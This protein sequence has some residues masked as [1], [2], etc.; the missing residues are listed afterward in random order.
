[1]RIGVNL[2]NLSEDKY[3]GVQQYLE[4]LIGHLINTGERLKLFLF[5]TYSP[6]DM[7]QYEHPK[8]K[9]IIVDKFEIP[10]SIYK[11]L[12]QYK[13]HLWFCPLHRSYIQ[14]ISI[15]TIPT[16][17]DV[18]HTAYPHFVPGGLSTNNNYYKKFSSNFAA[19]MTVSDFSKKGIV[20]HLGIPKDKVY[21]T[22]LDAP[23]I[24]N[25]PVDESRKRRIKAKYNLPQGYA[26]YPASYNPHKNHLKLLQALLILRD[27]YKLKI[28]LV[29]TG[30]Q[31]RRNPMLQ[32]IVNSIE[33]NGLKPQVKLLGYIPPT[34][35][36][37][38]YFNASFLVFPSLFEGFGIPL[39]EAMKTQTPIVCSTGGSIPEIVRDA[40][41]F[42]DPH[43]PQHMADKI[44]QMTSS[45]TYAALVQKG[46]ERSKAF[47]WEKC[48]Q[49]T[50]K[51]FRSVMH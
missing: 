34:D 43:S 7:F 49:E 42:F 4:N 25:Q 50:L 31:Y 41:L 15:P 46:N 16:I 45:A 27:K 10:S 51:V 18:L 22:Y 29:L 24:F 30:Y 44:L 26:L 37:Y 19:V 5:L 47:S 11:L 2:L 8:I 48:A 9:K 17:H 14:D 40:A 3:G 28:P 21:T 36:P 20:K 33:Q 6:R 39:V 32:S 1:M 38:L 23:K 35:M 13:I 12:H